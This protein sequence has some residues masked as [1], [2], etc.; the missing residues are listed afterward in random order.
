MTDSSSAAMRRPIG[1]SST[2]ARARSPIIAAARESTAAAKSDPRR[3]RIAF[4]P[5]DA[6]ERAG[7]TQDD[8]QTTDACKWF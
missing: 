5:P 2:V 4:P 3:F 8:R 1:A 7:Q 6:G